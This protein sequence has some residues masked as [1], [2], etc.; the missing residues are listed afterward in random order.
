MPARER[1]QLV[2]GLRLLGDVDT[3]AEHKGIR[4]R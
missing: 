1:I 2:F 4:A 3:M